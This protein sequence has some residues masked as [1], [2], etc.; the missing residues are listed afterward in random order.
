MGL[1][2]HAVYS[3]EQS[4]S[5]LAV[6]VF[7]EYRVRKERDTHMHHDDGDQQKRVAAD[8]CARAAPRVVLNII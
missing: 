8:V 7:L 3:V 1:A 4:P 5:T 6:G 2:R